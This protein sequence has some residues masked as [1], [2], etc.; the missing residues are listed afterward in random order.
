MVRVLALM[1]E[2]DVTMKF[3]NFT[4]KTE[5]P[6]FEGIYDI[7]PAELLQNKANVVMIDVRQ[8]EEYVGELGHVEG[9]S[10]MVLDT[11]PEQLGTLPK[12]KTV[13]FICRSGGRSAKA[14]AFA[15]MNGF[16]E[17][18]NM[19]GGMLLWNDLQLPVTK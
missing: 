19:Q 6:H 4:S 18:Y 8:P 1:P 2:E 5:N 11:L 3:V 17:V 10:L 13:V 16:E 15:K 9:S 12:D 7:G 14:T